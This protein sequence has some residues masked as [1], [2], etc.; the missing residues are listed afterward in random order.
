LVLLFEPRHM[1]LYRLVAW[2]GFV[3]IVLLVEWLIRRKKSSEPHRAF[4][5]RHSLT[6][7]L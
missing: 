5:L 1:D 7:M 2:L 4:A 3:P 6:A